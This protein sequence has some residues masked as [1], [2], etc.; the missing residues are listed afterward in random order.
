MLSDKVFPESSSVE[1]PADDSPFW[2]S[3]TGSGAVS[4]GR[5]VDDIWMLAETVPEGEHAEVGRVT[6]SRFPTDARPIVKIL[7]W[8]LIN[9]G[10]PQSFVSDHGKA[11][12]THLTAASN[13]KLIQSWV[14]LYDWLGER[15][16]SDIR[17]VSND[18]WL[19][20]AD[21]R[22]FQRGAKRQVS[23]LTLLAVSRLW[24]LSE[25]LRMGVARPPWYGSDDLAE[26]LP[27]ETRRAENS[28]AV[29]PMEVV[30]PLL[31]WAILFIDE[32]SADILAAKAEVDSIH[33]SFPRAYRHSRNEADEKVI[34]D[35]YQ[36][37]MKAGNP[38][39]CQPEGG[40]SFTFVG[41]QLG[42]GSRWLADHT[43]DTT[44]QYAL[45]R[46][47]PCSLATPVQGRRNGEP[48]TTAMD[49]HEIGKYWK[50]LGTA[51]LICIGYLTGMRLNELLSLKVGCCERV[52]G[53][54]HWMISGHASRKTAGVLLD[55]TGQSDWIAI[56]P[57]AR[58]IKVLE[59]MVGSGPLFA[60]GK[61]ELR[62]ARAKGSS[63]SLTRT[64]VNSR[65]RD[66]LA[67]VAGSEGADPGVARAAEERK[68]HFM[69]FR[70][71]LAYYIARRPG[72]MV[73]LAVQYNHMRWA[74]SEGYAS[75]R[76]D[77]FGALLEIETARAA[78]ATLSDIAAALENDGVI[79]GPG[80]A[81]LHATAEHFTHIYPGRVLTRAEALRFFE[82]SEHRVYPNPDFFSLCHF[83]PLKALCRQDP[84]PEEPE[85]PRLNECQSGCGNLVHT[86]GFM[87]GA[88]K[89]ADEKL[90]NPN[91]ASPAVFG[92]MVVPE[93]PGLWLAHNTEGLLARSHMYWM[94]GKDFPELPEGQETKTIMI[95]KANLLTASAMLVLMQEASEWWLS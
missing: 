24:A 47:G 70:R 1:L 59:K 85:R 34:L 68:L 75:R 57:A 83:D 10:V 86:D 76:R 95:P 14:Q 39:P 52:P 41:A 60:S 92:V 71:T 89:K 84:R 20:Y 91:R 11:T 16:I 7:G 69:Q 49:F 45:D 43:S 65:L 23:M 33:E 53:S 80:S 90:T 35:W 61:L 26:F 64:N 94:R 55:V 72:G 25:R 50:L 32:F 31:T 48:W 77:G 44:R 13:V 22:L 4:K 17:Q 28:T 67:F 21:E 73:A 8:L 36:A 5:F 78:A 30:A 19:A 40:I 12:V 81:R 15:G 62:P 51:A 63:K 56:G 88:T 2:T 54:E 42:T 87:H 79:S 93:E 82:V 58:A 27:P 9:E 38:I 3:S 29:I 18:T 46:P 37:Q 74:T 66:F 6:W